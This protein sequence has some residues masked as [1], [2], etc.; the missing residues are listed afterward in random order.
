MNSKQLSKSLGSIV[1]KNTKTNYLLKL[2]N[3]CK[4]L[5]NYSGI[6]ETSVKLAFNYN[7]AS[8][9]D[10]SLYYLNYAKYTYNSHKLTNKNIDEIYHSLGLL[11]TDLGYKTEALDNFNKAYI[12][13]LQNGKYKLAYHTKL[14]IINCHLDLKEYNKSFILINEILND[15]T[16]IGLN[17]KIACYGSMARIYQEQKLY[18]QAIKWLQKSLKLINDNSDN[19]RV[20]ETYNNLCVYYSK[21]GEYQ[22]ALDYGYKAL[23]HAEKNKIFTIKNTIYNSI[24]SVYLELGNNQKAK[25]YFNKAIEGETSLKL[26][27]EIIINFAKLYKNE[28][29]LKKTVLSYET[30]IKIID[31]IIKVKETN[32][33]KL[34]DSQRE[35]IEQNHTN[36]LLSTKNKRIEEK[37]SWQRL[38]IITLSIVIITSILCVCFLLKYKKGKRIIFELKTSEKKLLEEQIRLRENELDATDIYMSQNLQ[39]LTEIFSELDTVNELNKLTDVKKTIKNLI[40][41]TTASLTSIQDRPK[42]Q[43][44]ALVM[45]LLENHSELTET[46][47]RYCVLTKLNMSIKESANILKVTPNTVKVARSKIKKKMGIPENTNLKTYLDQ[48]PIKKQPKNK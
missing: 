11:Y 9:K 27:K 32:I 10:S 4:E 36:K 12:L 43:Y 40:Q 39:M 42:S 5:N 22:K 31:S 13:R 15:S 3:R 44:P 23:N 28:K 14:N 6:Y 19:Y 35:L 7:R 8:I 26:K 21:V 29:N 47:V 16:K 24:G 33:V 2:F 30:Y 46:E 48:L 34:F 1:Y 38:L 20:I 37:N 18:Q 25:T 17:I 45:K 41:S